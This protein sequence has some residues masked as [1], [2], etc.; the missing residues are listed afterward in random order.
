[1][2]SMLHGRFQ[3]GKNKTSGRKLKERTK[4]T[5]SPHIFSFF[6]YHIYIIYYIYIRSWGVH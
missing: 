6:S 3:E 4:I 1:H 5:I 2:A